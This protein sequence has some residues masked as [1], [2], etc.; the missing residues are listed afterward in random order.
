VADIA[1]EMGEP[2][3][4]TFEPAEAE[5]LMRRHG[6]DDIVHFGPA[7]A[8]ATYFAGRDDVHIHGAQRLMVAKVGSTRP[9]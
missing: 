9:A 8:L 1:A 6:F 5:E 7:E 2:F 4:T 3:V